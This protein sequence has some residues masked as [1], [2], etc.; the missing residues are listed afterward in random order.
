MFIIEMRAFFFRPQ[1]RLYFRFVAELLNGCHVILDHT[2]VNISYFLSYFD[3]ELDHK[4]LSSKKN[5]MDYWTTNS[6][7]N[8]RKYLWSYKADIM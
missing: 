1:I 6:N 2:S 4:Y 8:R 5:Y 3:I 7:V